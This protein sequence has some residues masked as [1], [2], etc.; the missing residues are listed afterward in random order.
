MHV[1]VEFRQRNLPGFATI[2]SALKNFESKKEFPWQLSIVVECVELVENRLPSS[3]EQEALY[4]FE[5]KIDPLVRS[6]G[7]ALFLAR[8]TYDGQR[9]LIWRIRNPE[10]V[11]SALQDVIRQKDHTREFDY[12][13]DE[14]PNWDKASWYLNSV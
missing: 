9:E 6:R 10:A 1:H 13:I 4:Q 12:R 2:N 8:T 14:D 3:A 5:D 11:N 7:D